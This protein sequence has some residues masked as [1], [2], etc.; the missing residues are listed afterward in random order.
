[1]HDFSCQPSTYRG[2]PIL[3]I[4]VDGKSW[5][6][7]FH[8]DEDF[9]FGRRKAALILAAG[10]FIEAFASSRGLSPPLH[11]TT[12]YSHRLYGRVTVQR[13]ASF[14]VYGRVVD[15]PYLHLSQD[16]VSI[17][18]GLNKTKATIELLPQIRHFADTA[19]TR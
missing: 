1:M 18:L 10:K 9:R 3:N 7:V 13:H 14:T 19:T 15:E 11:E 12:T 5:G 4:L 16:E 17:G 2:Q 8:Y 6:E